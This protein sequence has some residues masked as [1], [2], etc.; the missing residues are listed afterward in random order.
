MKLYLIHITLTYIALGFVFANYVLLREFEGLVRK[1]KFSKPKFKII[2]KAVAMY[3]A[4]PIIWGYY[5]VKIVVEE[6]G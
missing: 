5:V 2:A 3:L 6:I 4:L 1:I